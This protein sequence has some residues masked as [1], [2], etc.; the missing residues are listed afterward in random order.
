MVKQ[1]RIPHEIFKHI[2]SYKDPRYE[3]AL[4]GKKTDSAHAMPFNV[5]DEV[6]R[7]DSGL[8][9]LDLAFTM[10][11]PCSRLDLYQENRMI[12]IKMILVVLPKM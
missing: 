8:C 6:D 1:T 11:G 5:Y 7:L 4:R 3:A 2:L 10:V 12:L 9:L